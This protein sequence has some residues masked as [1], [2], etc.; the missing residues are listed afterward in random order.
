[1]MTPRLKITIVVDN[2]AGDGLL[3][4]HGLSL[5]IDT[6]ATRILFDTG[7]GAAL[8]DNARQLGIGLEQADIL[9]LSHGH[10][11]HTGGIPHVL[12]SARKINVYCHA[13]AVQPRYVVREGTATAIRMPS[14][15]MSAIDKLPEKNL[16]WTS[17]ARLV[18]GG[19][20]LTG[21]IPRETSFE[22]TGGPFFLDPQ[23]RRADPID[24]DLAL[25]MLTGRGLVV[26]V[27][28]CH[29]GIVNTLNHVFRL[30]GM[31]RLRALIGG[32]H[33]LNASEQ[34]LEQTVAALRSFSPELVVPCHCTGEKAMQ[35]LT[36]AFGAR[37]VP[38]RAGAA[39]GF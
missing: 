34:R 9:V 5:W 27:G 24:D 12:Q 6:G 15:S 32:F 7:Q 16:Y 29:A 37:V 8:A 18:A 3:A 22:D 35:M 14:A 36:A 2:Q 1:M 26:C 20:G 33:L 38:G 10:Y 21:P 23:A 13:A 11:D 31:N 4:E 25:W 39:Y 28:C 17:R 30:S 19:I